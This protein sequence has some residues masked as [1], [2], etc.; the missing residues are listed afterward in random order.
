MPSS[1]S[2]TY[3]LSP[4]LSFLSLSTIT[5]ALHTSFTSLH[6][7]TNTSTSTVIMHIP[8][9]FKKAQVEPQ[10]E[11]DQ[12]DMFIATMAP[13]GSEKYWRLHQMDWSR[14][15]KLLSLE[16]AQTRPEI[17]YRFV[18]KRNSIIAEFYNRKMSAPC[19]SGRDED[20][21]SVASDD[22]NATTM[23]DP[24]L[25]PTKDGGRLN[26]GQEAI[27]GE[28]GPREVGPQKVTTLRQAELVPL[29]VAQQRD[30]IKYR[31]E[32]FELN[33][34]IGAVKTKG[35]NKGWWRKI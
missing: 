3:S 15:P 32:A 26:Y 33:E 19:E 13:Y 23:S 20:S 8:R 30:N 18:S 1:A 21:F 25:N 2:T 34:T 29:W 16:E 10:P 31:P 24:S 7:F 12:Y 5:L 28:A 14:E 22:T 6:I 9:L 17:V 4:Y 35:T 11:L 27:F